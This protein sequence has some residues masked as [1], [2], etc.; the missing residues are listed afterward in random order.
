ME[1]ITN[2]A[3]KTKALAKTLAKKLKP[4]DVVA[5]FGDL[6]AGKTTFVQG[7]A[8]GLGIKKRKDSGIVWK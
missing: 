4:G 3:D 5:L 8:V 1:T 7:A 6:G 2:S